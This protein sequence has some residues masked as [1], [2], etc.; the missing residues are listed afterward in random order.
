[1]NASP[2]SVLAAAAYWS[3]ALGSAQAL[4]QTCGADITG[5]QRIESSD[6]TIVFRTQPEKIAVGEHFSVEFA[7]CPRANHPE[8]TGV[9]VNARM[10]EHHHGMNYRPTVKRTAG[11]YQADGLMF[12]MPGRWEISFGL[13]ADGKKEYL[14]RSILVK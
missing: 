11:H 12:H 4:A 2:A 6:Y 5:A 3:I 1:M 7:A 9:T 13:D 8:P 14:S 10:P